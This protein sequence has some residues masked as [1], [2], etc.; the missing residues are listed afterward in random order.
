MGRASAV[1]QELSA[2]NATEQA[3]QMVTTNANA[4]RPLPRWAQGVVWL[5]VFGA[6]YLVGSMITTRSIHLRLEAYRQNAPLFSSEIVGR[7]RFRLGLTDEQLAEVKEI[8]ERR[9]AKMLEYRQQGSLAM[10]QEFDAMAEEVANVL[11]E[12]QAERWYQI[13]RMVR[14]RF[15]PPTELYR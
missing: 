7:L 8:I 6:G 12:P 10:H 4:R 1:I 9:H 3:P 13:S 5:V 14:E 11:D 15:L 2:M